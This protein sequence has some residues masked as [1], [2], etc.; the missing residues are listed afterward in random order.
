MLSHFNTK[1][2]RVQSNPHLELKTAITEYADQVYRKDPTNINQVI[3][4]H[5]ELHKWKDK[6]LSA[7][8]IWEGEKLKGKAPQI[9]THPI[10]VSAVIEDSNVKT[11][12]GEMYNRVSIQPSWITGELVIVKEETHVDEL[13]RKMI[14]LGREVDIIEAKALLI[15]AILNDIAAGSEKAKKLIPESKLHEAELYLESHFESLFFKEH[16]A[17]FHVQHGVIGSEDN[18]IETWDL[19]RLSQSDPKE[20][21]KY[22][23]LSERIRS[24]VSS[25]LYD[26]T[27]K[28]FENRRE[29]RY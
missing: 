10:V 20:A 18:P 12:Y 16:P 24:S 3:Q 13:Q 15:P 17:L 4:T 2:D 14:F 23:Q 25:K 6:S 22:Q 1:K 5:P 28:H 19:V 29:L 11:S 26:E 8:R 9:F 21:E 27:L 7:S